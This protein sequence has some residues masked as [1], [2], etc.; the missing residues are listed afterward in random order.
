MKRIV[1]MVLVFCLGFAGVAQAQEVSFTTWLSKAYMGP[2][3]ALFADKVVQQGDLRIDLK[4]GLYCDVWGSTAFDRNKEYDKEA[5]YTCG[6]ARELAKKLKVDLSLAYFQVQGIDILTS[7]F[8]V[9]SGVVFF[10]VDAYKPRIDGGPKKGLLLN[11]GFSNN[12]QF[13]KH[14][15]FAIEESV[16]YDSGAFGF[17]RATLAQGQLNMNISV[18]RTTK[19]L[20]G[21][22]L[23]TPITTV[24]D[25]RKTETVWIF[26]LQRNF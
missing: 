5:D 8:M 20:L 7:S 25:G 1:A 10:R 26:G 18:S 22:K 12:F 13:G 2:N 9:R 15:E 6:I 14:L 3:G 11:G 17:D 21:L 24:H 16:R 23:S 4:N 19:L